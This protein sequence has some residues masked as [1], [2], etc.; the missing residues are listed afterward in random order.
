MI[1]QYM[2]KTQRYRSKI[3]WG[4][5]IQQHLSFKISLKPKETP[6]K[7]KYHYPEKAETVVH[8]KDMDYPVSLKQVVLFSLHNLP[9]GVNAL[10]A[11]CVTLG[12]TR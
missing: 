4:K 5:I 6:R 8:R 11:V 9:S 3:K 1:L 10:V 12:H 7:K 2:T